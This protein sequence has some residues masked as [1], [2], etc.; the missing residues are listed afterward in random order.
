MDNFKCLFLS[1]ATKLGQQDAIIRCGSTL[2]LVG[3]RS[4]SQLFARHVSDAEYLIMG[5]LTKI[6]E[7][8]EG[9][10]KNPLREQEQLGQQGQL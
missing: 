6:E 4:H 8:F 2:M 5:L 7:K 9:K 1:A 10:N 3:N